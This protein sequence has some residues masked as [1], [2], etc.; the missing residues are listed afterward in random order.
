LFV[1]I[2]AFYGE[3]PPDSL[4]VSI[5]KVTEELACFSESADVSGCEKLKYAEM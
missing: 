2:G 4:A 1:E 5:E 3:F